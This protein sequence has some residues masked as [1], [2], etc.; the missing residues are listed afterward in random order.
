MS[1]SIM[2]SCRLPA[3]CASL[4]AAGGTAVTWGACCAPPVD[5]GADEHSREQQA[6]L[7]GSELGA[8]ATKGTRRLF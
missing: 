6:D 4:P 2:H 7:A 5:L 1:V 8:L 3:R